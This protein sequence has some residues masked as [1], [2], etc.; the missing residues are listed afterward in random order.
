M[1]CYATMNVSH[2]STLPVVIGRL[3]RLRK[4][5]NPKMSGYAWLRMWLYRLVYTQVCEHWLYSSY[6]RLFDPTLSSPIDDIVGYAMLWNER[7]VLSTLPVVM[8]GY[9]GYAKYITRKGLVTYG[10]GC[11]YAALCT[12]KCARTGY[13]RVTH[14]YLTPLQAARWTITLV[15]RGYAMNVSHTP[16]YT[17]LW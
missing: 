4:V 11:G 7:F 9:T 5:H 16:R 1:Q 15:M 10:H 6:A 14:G 8:V 2:V 12:P 3:Y 17:W 13:G